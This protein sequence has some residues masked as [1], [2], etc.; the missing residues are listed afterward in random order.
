MH[1]KQHA[2]IL[3]HR[4]HSPLGPMFVCASEQGVCLLEFAVSRRVEREFEDLQRLLHTRIVAGENAHTRQAE[5][6]IGE[7]FAGTRQQFGVALHLPGT[8]F[9]QQVWDAL[10]AIPYGD[11]A[12][13]QQQAERL[14]NPAAIRAVAGANG[15]N[16]VSII[17]PCHR[18][19]GKDGSLT[20]YGGGLQRKAWLLQHE[21]RNRFGEAQPQLF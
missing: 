7:Y 15:A 3:L 2:P 12:S 1:S 10:Q 21:Q 18:V 17:V 4:F 16:R 9:Q 19:I 11:T 20:G 13:Y 8:A 14:G 5:A 6:E